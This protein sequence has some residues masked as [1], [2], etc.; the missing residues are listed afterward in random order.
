[1]KL[2]L[3]SMLA[4]WATL[5]ATSWEYFHELWAWDPDLSHASW[6]QEGEQTDPYVINL[7]YF[8]FLSH[9]LHQKIHLIHQ[10]VCFFMETK[11]GCFPN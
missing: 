4:V 3:F 5:V 10:N 11:I 2:T 9:W 6:P 7:G 1:M 8:A